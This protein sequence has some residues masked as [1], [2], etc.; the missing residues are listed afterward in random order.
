MSSC[1]WKANRLPPTRHC[2]TT[3]SGAEP[4]ASSH[5]RDRHRFVRAHADLRLFLALCLEVEP[6]NVRYETGVHG[7][8]RLLPGLPPLE[9]NLSHSERLD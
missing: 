2:S 3:R 1:R 9:F 4:D 8:P 5:P 7:K 6:A